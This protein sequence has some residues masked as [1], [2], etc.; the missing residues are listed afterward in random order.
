MSHED[1]GAG[2]YPVPDGRLGRMLRLGGLTS[3]IMGGMLATGAARLARG[4]RPRLPDMLLTPATASRLTRELGRE[5]QE[6]SGAT[7]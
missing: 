7:R 5:V 1:H 4:E 3:G 2:A 6:L